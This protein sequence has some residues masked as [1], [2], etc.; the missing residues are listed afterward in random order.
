MERGPQHAQAVEAIEAAPHARG[1]VRHRRHPQRQLDRLLLPANVERPAVH[2]IEENPPLRAGRRL[3]HTDDLPC[4]AVA[5]PARTDERRV[6]EECGSTGRSR[7]SPDR[8]KTKTTAK[9]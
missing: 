5:H 8:Y 2:D 1:N 3:E 4:A 6:G 9:T 7:V